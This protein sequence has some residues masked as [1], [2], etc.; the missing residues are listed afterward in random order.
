MR[1]VTGSS[2]SV[3]AVYIFFAEYSICNGKKTPEQSLVKT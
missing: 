1:V 2:D 3:I